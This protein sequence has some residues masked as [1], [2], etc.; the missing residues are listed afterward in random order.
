MLGV[1]KKNENPTQD[2]Q[3]AVQQQP[4]SSWFE[5]EVL[6][7]IVHNLATGVR[8]M[9][10]TD[11]ESGNGFVKWPYTKAEMSMDI[12]YMEQKTSMLEFH[13]MCVTC[14]SCLT[15]GW[16]GLCSCC[17]PL[18]WCLVPQNQRD[19]RIVPLTV[20][21]CRPCFL[22]PTCKVQGP[23]YSQFLYAIEVNDAS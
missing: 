23:G 9:W 11:E 19:S 21:W 8:Q 12:V 10:R 17:F 18:E 13:N 1:N 6:M 4:L 20:P 16:W 14:H 3:F 15:Y 22:L 7:T 2:R 5:E